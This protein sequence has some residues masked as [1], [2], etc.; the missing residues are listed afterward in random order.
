[1]PETKNQIYEK[2]WSIT[3][4]YTDIHANR[5]RATLEAIVNF[6]D[7]NDVSQYDSKMYKKLQKVVGKA[8][9][10]ESTSLRKSI[11]QFVKLGFIEYQLKSYHKDSK[12][13]LEAKTNR[14]RETL[15]S[16]IVYENSSFNRD[17][18]KNSKNR[19][20]NFLLKTLEEVGKLSK[21]DIIALMIQDIS[22]YPKGYLT[23]E[24]LNE[25]K[26]NAE[27]IR[28]LE[29][30]Y[31]QVN[32]FRTILN[33]LDE[34]VFVDDELYFEE[35]AKVIFGEEL[36]REIRV[37]DNY[38]HIL[39]KNQLKEESEEKEGKIKCMVELLDYPSLVASH[40]KPFI[41]AEDDEAY[42]PENGLLLSRN[43]DILFDQGYITF[44]GTGR[45]ILSSELSDDLK[46]F[47]NGYGL[48]KNYLTSKRLNYLK[49][50]RENVFKK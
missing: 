16:K 11:N 31:N 34:L 7:S 17:V 46:K 26:Q 1:M 35:D 15:F 43:M 37:R 41:K 19:E 48:K 39:Y 50:H 8:N 44:T 12:L 4:A 3:L 38:L 20:I 21:E 24:E 18:T 6:I 2:Y 42:D 30:K 13:F 9:L 29:R 40:I 28:F 25:A 33:K 32:H 23:R 45:I 47:L 49:Y 10:L 27:E 22:N 14:K 36:K 5:F